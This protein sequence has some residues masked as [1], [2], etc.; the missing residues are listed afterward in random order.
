[1]EASERAVRLLEEIRDLQRLALEEARTRGER[2]LAVQDAAVKQ[3]RAIGTFY[4]W[5]VGVSALLILPL[6]VW[7][8]TRL[9]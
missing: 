6:I 4:R 5:V 3:Q 7:L 8:L 9:G 1:M 2:A